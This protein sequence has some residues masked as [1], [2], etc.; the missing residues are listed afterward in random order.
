MAKVPPPGTMLPRRVP[1]FLVGTVIGNYPAEQTV[2]VR[3]DSLGGEERHH[4]RYAHTPGVYS[5]P[6]NGDLAVVMFN[7]DAELLCIGFLDNGYEL[8]IQTEKVDKVNPGEV[9]IAG[10]TELFDKFDQRIKFTGDGNFSLESTYGSG[11]FY[12]AARDVLEQ[13]AS[14]IIEETH[15]GKYVNGAVLRDISI[16]PVTVPQTALRLAQPLVEQGFVINDILTGMP[17]VRFLIGDLVEEVPPYPPRL[18]ER[19][20]PLTAILEVLANAIPLSGIELDNAGNVYI[21]TLSGMI[22]IIGNIVSLKAVT[23]F[24]IEAGTSVSITAPDIRLGA[25]PKPLVTSDILSMLINHT[26]PT[27]DGTTLPSP[28][29]SSAGSCQTLV[30]K[31]G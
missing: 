5:T 23:T 25:S 18:S 10:R 24:T 9:V 13:R 2:D 19:G 27:P 28:E 3:F 30:V 16:G 8:G 29:L 20:S 26:H 31:G 11:I 12:K 7:S 17:R 4:V 21:K 15:A 1:T 6:R 22:I 14:T